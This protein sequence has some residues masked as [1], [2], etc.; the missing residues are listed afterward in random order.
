[1]Y[2]Y[3]FLMLFTISAMTA[4]SMGVLNINNTT[5][6]TIKA[7]DDTRILTLW[8]NSIGTAL[9]NGGISN[10]LVPPA[11]AGPS[12]KVN[13]E[14]PPEWLSAPRNNAYGY[15]IIYCPIAQ[16]SS[17]DKSLPTAIIKTRSSSYS[18]NII[19]SSNS[20]DYVVSSD[21]KLHSSIPR[22][23]VLA[24]IISQLGNDIPSCEDVRYNEAKGKFF[25][26]GN[27]GVVRAITP[28][29]K[30]N[31]GQEKE[32]DNSGDNTDFSSALNA[33]QFTNDSDYKLDTNKEGTF[34]NDINIVKFDSHNSIIISS[35]SLSSLKGNGKNISL[36][37]VKLVLK[38][39]DLSAFSSIT[40]KNGELIVQDS[41]IPS[42]TLD[43]TKSTF[44]GS[45]SILGNIGLSNSSVNQ[46]DSRISVTA[47]QNIVLTNST[48]SA[49]NN[50]ITNIYSSNGN[51]P[52]T[53][54]SDS[55][56]RLTNSSLD[57][58]SNLFASDYMMYIDPGS[59]FVGYNATIN[60]KSRST[61]GVYD[62]GLLQLNSSTLTP[63]VYAYYLIQVNNGGRLHADSSILGSTARRNIYGVVL[64]SMTY[65]SGSRTNVYSGSQCVTGSAYNS[66]KGGQESLSKNISWTC[67]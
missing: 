35:S 36:N 22:K 67:K 65:V 13:Y 32:E 11:G 29:S 7:V 2:A 59:K 40:V 10:E 57:L 1:M 25:V 17:V 21:I 26:I 19:T 45:S 56:F 3:V 6:K 49:S 30:I 53:L 60:L 39:V 41:V 46:T 8:E 66:V 63:T 48:W 16:N 58:R 4:A 38:N 14:T 61:I 52:L 44:E 42:L 51:S 62:E 5:Q 34:S 31:N 50:S 23:N 12:S 47:N 55:N 64:D 28:A 54:M 33:W 18:A 43:N 27:K 24:F 15:P 9:I 37:G 20:H